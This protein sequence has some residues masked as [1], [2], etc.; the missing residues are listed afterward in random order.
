MGFGIFF[1]LLIAL[2]SGDEGTTLSD[3]P[4]PGSN[5]NC[6]RACPLRQTFP[7]FN[8]SIQLPKESDEHPYLR[9][10]ISRRNESEGEIEEDVPHLRVFIW[11]NTGNGNCSISGQLTNGVMR[12]K[13]TFI[14][15][16]AGYKE[17]LCL[18]AT[19]EVD[20]LGNQS[21]WTLPLDSPKLHI[22]N[23]NA[24]YE[25]ILEGNGTMAEYHLATWLVVLVY[26][27]FCAVF[28][29]LWWLLVFPGTC[30]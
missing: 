24:T 3:G 12:K 25:V 29:L 14:V 28:F 10:R 27:V 19:A 13:A 4:Q 23:F 18:T 21:V 15:E 22:D 26:V 9:L 5:E 16:T 11:P 17:G 1:V 20:P 2:G 30:L 8:D 7:F 6:P